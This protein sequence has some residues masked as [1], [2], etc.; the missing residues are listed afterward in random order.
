[1]QNRQEDMTTGN[2]TT[3]MKNM[4]DQLVFYAKQHQLPELV[5][6][7][8]QARKG[9]TV[10]RKHARKRFGTELIG[11]YAAL[12]ISVVKQQLAKLDIPL[13]RLTALNS[14][15]D[16]FVEQANSPAQAA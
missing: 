5:R 6:A 15:L 1:M 16:N 10:I 8:R 4:V 3:T 2:D 14:L 13:E 7:G 11:P 9:N 12:I